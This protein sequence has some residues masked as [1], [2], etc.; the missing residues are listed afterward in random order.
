M[1]IFEFL[2][3]GVIVF[4]IL[5]VVCLLLGLVLHACGFYLIGHKLVAMSGFCGGW[6]ARN[7]P[8]QMGDKCECWTCPKAADKDDGC[9]IIHAH[10]AACRAKRAKRK[11]ARKARKQASARK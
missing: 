3:R 8:Y 4:L 9:L 10:W 11:A 7:C 2:F 5:N 1:T 6:V